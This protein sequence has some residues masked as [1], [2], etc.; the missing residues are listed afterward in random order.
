MKTTT[1]FTEQ[2]TEGFTLSEL[3]RLNN[4][5]KERGLIELDLNDPL[6]KS[7]YDL[8]CRRLLENKRGQV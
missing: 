4:M 5:A 2:N 6:E 8:G 1:I 3:D 7:I